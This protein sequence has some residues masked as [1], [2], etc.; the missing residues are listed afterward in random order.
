MQEKTTRS[1]DN[2]GRVTLK[3]IYDDAIIEIKEELKKRPDINKR[4]VTYR[5]FY[6]VISA[7]LTQIFEIVLGGLSYDLYNRFGNI[8]IIKT[9]ITRAEPKYYIPEGID[10]HFTKGYWHFLFW[11]CGKKWRMFEMKMSKKYVVEMMRKVNKGFEYAS[12]TQR[13]NKEGHIYKVR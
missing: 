2:H 5:E 12:R 13:N 8:R 1:L 7:Y 6:G 3:G 10:D 9:K 11:D 4:T